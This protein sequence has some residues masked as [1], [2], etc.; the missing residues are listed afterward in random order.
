MPR[1]HHSQEEAEFRVHFDRVSVGKDEVLSSLLLAREDDGDLLCCNGQHWQLNAVEFIEATPGTRLSETFG[2][3][4][5]SN[6]LSFIELGK[7][8]GLF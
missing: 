3:K 8:K 5:T 4:Q 1:S 6:G 7:R 2:N